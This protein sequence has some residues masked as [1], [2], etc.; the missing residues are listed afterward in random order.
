MNDREATHRRAGPLAAW[1]RRPLREA[2]D[3]ALR[4]QLD[5]QGRFDSRTMVVLVTAAFCLT[6]QHYIFYGDNVGDVAGVLRWLGLSNLAE[7]FTALLT[8]RENEEIAA[9]TFWALG[10]LCTYVVIPTLVT[11]FILRRSIF[12]YGLKVR[13]AIRSAPL[14]FAM[15]AVMLPAVWFFS[16]TESFQ[17]KYP[18]YDLM[19]GESLWPRF[20][21][22]EI[23]YAMQ[24]VALEFF[25]RGFI[26]HGT[27]HRFGSASIFVMTLAY[28]LIHWEKPMPECVGSIAAGLVLGFMSLKTFSIWWGAALHIAVAWSMDALAVMG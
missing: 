20:I 11:W 17:A 7:R 18:F 2:D 15:L 9:L 25:F 12:E 10:R 8:A 5:N 3:A 6:I 27:K 21:M 4:W 19:D 13:G 16:R 28:C 24:F 1:V 14:Y 22:W 23:L 26:L